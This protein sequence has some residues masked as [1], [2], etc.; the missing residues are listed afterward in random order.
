MLDP[1]L[2]HLHRH[3]RVWR[4]TTE[5]RRL[6]R[7]LQLD[8]VFVLPAVLMLAFAPTDGWGSPL[9][10]AL[11][12]LACVTTA[13]VRF[14]IGPGSSSPLVI[15]FIPLWYCVPPAWLTVVGGVVF[16]VARLIERWQEEQSASL[17]RT[18]QGATDAWPLIGP[19][20]VFAV[21]GRPEASVDEVGTFAL[22]LIASLVV[23]LFIAL[24][25][26]W[27]VHGIYPKL[28]LRLLAWV[29]LVDLALAP[30]G[31]LGAIA[32]AESPWA[33]ASLI[34][35]VLV[36]GEFARERRSRLDQAVQLSSAYRGTA[37]LM[38][39]VLEADHQ[40]TGG[41]HTQ[42]VV[43]LAVAVGLEL[44]LPPR[45]MR[46]LEFGA[47]LH[48]IGKLRVPNEIINKPG[49]L[50]D[51]EWLVMRRHPEY[52]QEMLDRVGGALTDAG[53]IVRAHHERWDGTG[54]PDGLA[55]DEI[56]IEARIITVCD[57][58]SAMTTERSYS[59]ART[60]R[61]ARMELER[62][63]GT[64]FD[65]AVVAALA[66]VLADPSALGR[67]GPTSGA[68]IPAAARALGLRSTA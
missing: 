2:E 21:V 18:L 57:S 37:Q 39:D 68:E 50:S 32:A 11:V 17:G 15:G 35:L 49:A 20:L 56:P 24:V 9:T 31:F 61:Q 47:L 14:E 22:A 62:C 30:V 28:Q 4:W 3:G 55:G 67:L 36:L 27:Y 16:A 45:A 44:R 6:T 53:R 60:D 33:I 46:D 65:P 66:V 48:D 13:L 12:F 58:Y 64:Q 40:Y 7:E 1:G 54:Y 10:V 23:D 25:S 42:G 51:A 29:G 52:G 63:S 59:R 38:G 41:E 19:A 5:R 34:P 43:D 8:L 26:G